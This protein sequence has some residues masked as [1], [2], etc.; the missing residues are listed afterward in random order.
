MRN[1][2]TSD[3]KLAATLLHQP[4][5]V[6]ASAG[7]GKT[8][9]MVERYLN[10][11]KAGF[12]PKNIL[13]VTFTKE[14]A[15]QL[16]DRI[17][18]RL[19]EEQ[20]DSKWQEDVVSCG[21]IGTLHSLCY[22]ILNQ[23]GTELGFPPVV[24][25]IDNFAFSTAFLKHYNDWLVRLSPESL[26]KLLDYF[27]HR[28]LK[29]MTRM[30][31]KNR[32][33]FFDCIQLA[34]DAGAKDVA[35]KVILLLGTELKPFCDD[36]ASFF[37]EQGHYSFDDLEQLALKILKESMIARTRLSEDFQQILVDEFQ[38]TS[39]VQWQILTLLLGDNLNKLF[40]VG[41]PKQSIYGFR[42]AEPALFDEVSQ[43]MSCRGGQRIDLIHNFRSERTLLEEFNF[44]SSHLFTGQSFNWNPMVSGLTSP[45]S[46]GS[47]PQ[48]FSVCFFGPQDK[49]PRQAIYEEEVATVSSH[50][51]K[52]L[53]RGVPPGTIALL[54]RNSDRISEFSDAFS[55]R[56]W[57]HQCKK[58]DNLS[59]Q[60]SA[61]EIVSFLKFLLDPTQDGHLVTF[62]RSIYMNWSYAQVLNLTQKR[63]KK[64]SG[65]F[66]PLIDLIRRDTPQELIWL[67]RLLESGQTEVAHCLETLFFETRTF[68][69]N[70]EAFDALLGPLSQPGL[71]LFEIQLLL[72]SFQESDFLYQE[73]S[74][75]ANQQEGIQLMTVHA[76]KG[77]EFNHVILVDTARLLPQDSPSLLLKAGLPPGIKYWEQDKKIFSGSYQSL[78]DERKQ[79][80]EEESKRILYVA[81]TRARKSL[82]VFLPQ[83]A[84]LSYPRNSWAD[85]LI[86]A[87]V[88]ERAREGT[89]RWAPSPLETE[90]T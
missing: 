2:M 69:S 53:N 21:T 8:S 42:Q 36:L 43:L 37:H 73:T 7:S 82:T 55:K 5:S 86:K 33:L 26:N 11:L 6:M 58:T 15:E 32:H 56:G 38:D 64:E 28:E 48:S 84:A 65:K 61:I 51:E 57:A 68:P 10:L 20:L 71:N 29:E 90:F 50:V 13:T 30:V 4:L 9:T 27:T 70:P 74:P 63:Q 3:Q 89:S 62:L 47:L 25:I 39:P 78:L 67:L 18:E 49:A 44:I 81:L 46:T 77:L 35:A 80:D 88:G 59:K 40:I 31:Y 83:E 76:S 66:E 85:L 52:L 14:A 87:G 23:Y 60:I 22:S 34:Q 75:S 24:Q 12:S 1:S 45:A 54:F 17:I 79:K 41:D 16:R 72:D 19:L